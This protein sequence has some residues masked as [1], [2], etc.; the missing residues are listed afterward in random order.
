MA[1]SWSDYYARTSGLPPGSQV[2]GFLAA[3]PCGA[4]VLDFG[5]GSGRYAAAFMR[6]RPDLVVD[7]L[8]QNIG[9]A[10][11]LAD[12]PPDR[13]LAEHFEDWCAAPESYDGIWARSSLYFLP[14]PKLAEVFGRLAVALKRGG[15]FEFTL[16]AEPG[17]RGFTAISRDGVKAMLADSG[18]RARVFTSARAPYAD[19]QLLMTHRVRARK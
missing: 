8:D 2:A 19:G 16:T 3:L 10:P 13:L 14:A 7:A 15:V 9:R 6:D 4:R 12:W 17:I 18:L 5:T 11:L 1:K